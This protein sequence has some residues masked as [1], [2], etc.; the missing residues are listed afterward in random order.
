MEFLQR[1]DGPS[2]EWPNLSDSSLLELL[3]QW[4]GPFLGGK[5]RL[6]QV[7]R[8]D[9]AQPLQALL[10]WEHR[11]Q[12][13]RRAPTHMTVP[14]GSRL[15]V[16]YETSDVPIL[17][18]K[19]QEMFGAPDT[20]T[21]SEGQV[22]VMLHLLSPAGRPVQVTQNLASFWKSGYPEVR[23]EL[24]GRY[25]KHPWPEDP[26]SAQPTRRAKPRK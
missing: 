1:V 20:P 5:T 22:P 11:R 9:L 12:L 10:T 3:E 8:M 25:P 13:E 19:L 7:Q 6:V 14:S 2:S 15:R 23:K 17:P 26:L 18:V 4:L 21:L 24:R 16:D